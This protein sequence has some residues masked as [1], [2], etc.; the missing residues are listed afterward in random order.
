MYPGGTGMCRG[1]RMRTEVKW[2]VY[3]KVT[4]GRVCVCV[5]STYEKKMCYFSLLLKSTSFT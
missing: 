5:K 3:K 2:C 1:R 4:W